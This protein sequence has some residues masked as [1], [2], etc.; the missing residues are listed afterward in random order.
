MA[1]ETSAESPV[2]VRTVLQLV[3]GWVQRLGRVWGDGEIAELARRGGTG[4]VTLRDPAAAV[5]GRVICTRTVFDSIRP[6]PAEGARVV[7]YAKPDFNA[8]RGSFALTALD[9][10]PVGVGEL[11]ARLEQLRHKLAAEGLFARDRKRPLPFLPREIGLIC[12]RDS[13]AQRDGQ[14]I[15]ARRWPAVRFRAEQTAVQGSYAAGEVVQ[16]LCRLDRDP[17]VDV[18][19]LAPGGG[20]Q[21]DSGGQRERARAGRAAAGPRG[22]PARGHPDRRGQAGGAGR[23][24]AAGPDRGAAGPG[25][26]GRAWPGRAGAVRADRDDVAAGHRQPGPGDRAAAGAGGPGDPAGPGQP[27]GGHHPGRGR[28]VAHPGPAAGAVPRVHA[29]ARLR[30]RPARGRAGGAGRG[31]GHR[32]RGADRAVRRGPDR[33]DRRLA[34]RLS[35][36]VLSDPIGRLKKWRA[37]PGRTSPRTKI[38]QRASRR[39]NRRQCPTSRPG[40]S[41]RRWSSGWRPAG[42][43][44][45]RRR[46]W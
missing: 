26:A 29:E 24:R 40:M 36:P 44:W 20:R 4:F 10:R 35:V 21:P 11:L 22:P 43:G 7:V 38:S 14:R 18:V 33:R 19:I 25:P 16:A 27:A 45:G 28:G 2:P 37:R 42:W 39:P 9:I 17:D 8:T 23:G 12:G 15:A 34:T 46:A 6:A 41:S 31:R 5:S 3:G 1:L 30:D 13:A 32:G